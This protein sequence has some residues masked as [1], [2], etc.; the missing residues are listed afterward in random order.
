M[1]KKLKLYKALALEILNSGKRQ[2]AKSQRCNEMH[3]GENT[4]AE[5]MCF[6]NGDKGLGK[7]PKVVKNEG[8][9]WIRLPS[10][11]PLLE[12]E[13]QLLSHYNRLAFAC[14]W[15]KEPGCRTKNR[16]SFCT[17]LIHKFCMLCGENESKISENVWYIG[18]MGPVRTAYDNHADASTTTLRAAERPTE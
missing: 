9:H 10:D 4:V 17:N 6:R 5:R 15:E 18:P 8:C 14:H 13:V 3:L 16:T 11:H 12:N 7:Q 1:V 2:R